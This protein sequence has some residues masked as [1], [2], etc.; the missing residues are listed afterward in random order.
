MN[1]LRS[2]TWTSHVTHESLMNESRT[3]TS[4]VP[5]ESRINESWIQVSHVY[6]WV[7]SRMSHAWMRHILDWVTSRISHVRCICWVSKS[8]ATKHSAISHEQGTSVNESWHMR[9]SHGAWECIMAQGDESLL[10]YESWHT[11][12]GHVYEYAISHMSY[13]TCEYSRLWISHGTHEWGMTHMNESW[14]IWTGGS[15]F[16]SWNQRR[17]N[18]LQSPSGREWVMSMNESWRMWMSHGIY[19][20]V[21]VD[22]AVEIKDANTKC[23][24]LLSLIAFNTAGKVCCSVLQ[25]VAVCCS[26]LQCP[27]LSLIAFN[28]AGREYIRGL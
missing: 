27:L 23:N 14:H 17:R 22:L 19:E 9:T 21:A 15:G 20:Q 4:H 18:A 10:L 16:V 7:T 6:R 3:G 26:V 1:T 25:C 11:R 2:C 8:Q 28:V 13:V 12:M 24:P 5:H